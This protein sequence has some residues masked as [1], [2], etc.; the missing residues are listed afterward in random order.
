ML[1]LDFVQLLVFLLP[2]LYAYK[3]GRFRLSLHLPPSKPETVDFT[4]LFVLFLLLT[5][6]LAIAWT[7]V[8][9]E[10]GWDHLV[11]TQGGGF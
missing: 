9:W 7:S 10:Y 5:A 8:L 6:E 3:Q 11:R 2:A 4:P 1:V